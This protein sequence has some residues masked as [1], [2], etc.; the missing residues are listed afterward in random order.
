MGLGRKETHSGIQMSPGI[1]RG[2]GNGGGGGSGRGMG[3]RPSKM[4][5]D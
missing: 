3:N 2:C 4:H 5:M 1:R